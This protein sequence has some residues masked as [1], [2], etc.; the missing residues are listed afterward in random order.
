MNP[1]RTLPGIFYINDA[2]YLTRCKQE[3]KYLDSRTCTEVSISTGSK[4]FD[5]VPTPTK[6]HHSKE[7]EKL[8]KMI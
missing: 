4:K 2:K 6:I 5:F 7:L 1:C 3:I 8:N